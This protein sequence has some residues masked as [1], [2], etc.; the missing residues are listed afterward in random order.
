MHWPCRMIWMNTVKGLAGMSHTMYL[1]TTKDMHRMFQGV[2]M[3]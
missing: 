3:M 2:S 1:V